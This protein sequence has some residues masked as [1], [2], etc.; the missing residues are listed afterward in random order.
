MREAHNY[1][2]RLHSPVSDDCTPRVSEAILDRETSSCYQKL[3]K[4]MMQ[5]R[6]GGGEAIADLVI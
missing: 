2:V 1:V 5:R 4:K 3:V 6:R